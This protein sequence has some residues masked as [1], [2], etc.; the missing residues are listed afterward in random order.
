MASRATN[1]DLASGPLNGLPQPELIIQLTAPWPVRK[2]YRLPG[3]EPGDPEVWMPLPSEFSSVC[4]SPLAND[5][6]HRIY[7]TNPPGSPMAGAWWNTYDRLRAGGTGTNA[8]WNMGFIAPDPNSK[9]TVSVSGGS[10]PGQ[11]AYGADVHTRGTGYVPGSILTVQGGTLGSGQTAFTVRIFHT[12][13]VSFGIANPGSGGINGPAIVIGT[14]G[15]GTPVRLNVTISGGQLT[16]INSVNTYGVYT[17]NPTNLSNEPVTGGNLVG[18]AIT[19]V[20]GVWDLDQP[21]NSTYTV[22]PPWPSDT[23]SSGPGTGCKVIVNTAP[24]GNPPLEDRV[25]VYTFID[26]YGSESSPCGPSDVVSGPANGT[27]TI[28]GFPTT[29]PATPA[30]KNY[31]P[32]VKMRI[33]RTLTAETAGAQFYFVADK[34]FGTATYVDTIP[35]TTVVNG[36]TLASTSWLPPVDGLDGLI[37]MPGGMLVGFTA[38]TVHFCEPNRPHA[39]PAGYDQSLI[40]PIVALAIW[41]QSLIVLTTGYPSTGTGNSPSQFIFA[42]IQ[43]PEPCIARGSVVTDLAGVYYASPNGLVSLNYYG[44]QNQTLSNLTREIWQKR[45]QAAHIVACRHRAQ[46]LAINGTGMGFVID[47]TE[48]RMGIS[49]LSPFLDVVSVWNDVYNGNAYMMADNTVYLW[50]SMNTPALPYRWRS[51][52]FYM[53]APASLGACQISLDP[54]VEEK[55]PEPLTAIPYTSEPRSIELPPGVNAIFRLYVGGEF[56]TLVHEQW[57]QQPRCIFRLPSGRKA[58]NWQF[59]LVARVPIHSVEL[60]STMRELKGV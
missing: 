58:F 47:Y 4:H 50:D 27:W 40:Y 36:N 32:P 54:V 9:L 42:Q 43:T 53:Q 11:V 28:S 41:Q 39:W 14:T 7:W 12:V 48:E 37:S 22:P 56:R 33:Y 20:M 23:T 29:P 18:A 60:A 8:P 59:E 44:A 6:G 57:L 5:T 3:P 30:G 52:E 16:A 17:T 25:Y 49:A 38:E 45:F 2:A 1:V 26:A 10:Y 13:T 31:P 55:A 51:R 24:N 35:S 21:T 19:M 34:D 15:S 46:Y